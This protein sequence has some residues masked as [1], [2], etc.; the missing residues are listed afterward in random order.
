MKKIHWENMHKFNTHWIRVKIFNNKPD[1]TG[2]PL[3]L[4]L[5]L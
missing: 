4:N 3:F 1:I 2:V 5:F